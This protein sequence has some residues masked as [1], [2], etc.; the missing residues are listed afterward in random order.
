MN[1]PLERLMEDAVAKMNAQHDEIAALRATQEE[2]KTALRDCVDSLAYVDSHHHGITGI[3]VRAARI[4]Y[5]NALLSR[6]Q[7]PR[8][9]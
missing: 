9:T 1:D 3:A 7:S 5:G 8:D 4:A 6:L 2:L